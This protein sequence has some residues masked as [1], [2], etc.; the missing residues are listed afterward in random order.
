M[1]SR[2]FLLVRL[3]PGMV[4]P[5]TRRA[6]QAA[7]VVL[8]CL[9]I[10]GFGRR[11]ADSFQDTP[12]FAFSLVGNPADVSTETKP[13]FV[14]EGGGTDI[15][16]SFTWMI[17][18]SG[19]GDFVVIRTSGTDAYNPYIQAMTTPEGRRADSVST[20]VFR[21]RAASFNPFVLDTLPC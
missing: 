5:A 10:L 20:L 15:D 16:D 8:V 19:G 9:A 12:L 2:G 14:L 17:D 7:I 6:A 11:S 3:W 4:R 18:R 13:G 21:D 1:I